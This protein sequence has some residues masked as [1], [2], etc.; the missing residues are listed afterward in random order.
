VSRGAF[1]AP[2]RALCAVVAAFWA[3]LARGDEQAMWRALIREREVLIEDAGGV[4]RV[5]SR[6]A[7]SAA[8]AASPAPPAVTG[9]LG[10]PGDA[11]PSGDA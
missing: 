11:E 8:P 1:D 6:S 5:P 10:E 7:N 2:L 9:P 4:S 3:V